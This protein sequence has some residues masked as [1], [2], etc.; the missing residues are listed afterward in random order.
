MMLEQ[1]PQLKL[2]KWEEQ[3]ERTKPY[4]EKAIKYQDLYTIDDVADK[5]RDGSFLLWPGTRSAMI[6][7][8]IDFPQKKV[9]NLLFCGGDYE[10]LEK[11]TNEVE[12]FAKK[13]GCQ[14]LYGGGRKAWIRKIKH[15]GWE[16]DYTIRK[17]IL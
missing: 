9:C 4:I 6:T 8:F 17:E 10:E 3:W 7:E 2:Y 13:L 5:I 11:I 14:R 16:N 1:S 15:L 12:R